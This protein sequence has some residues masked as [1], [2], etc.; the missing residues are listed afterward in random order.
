MRWRGARRAAAVVLGVLAAAGPSAAQAPRPEPIPELVLVPLDLPDPPRGELLIRWPTLVDRRDAM[1]KQVKDHN[2]RCRSV[3]EKSPKAAECVE[4]QKGVRATIAAWAADARRFNADVD[5][6]A[7]QAFAAALQAEAAALA[8]GREAWTV[9]AEA[10]VR[11]AVARTRAWSDDVRTAIAALTIPSPSTRFS[12]LNNLEPGDVL[13]LAP[14]DATGRI[15]VE[16]DRFARTAESFATGDVMQ[17]YATDRREVAHAVTVVKRVAGR[18]LILDHT[19]AGSRMLGERD[20]QRLYGGRSYYVARPRDA[21]DGRTLWSVARDAALQ[22]KSDYGL[23][24][25]KAVC[26]ERAAV[27][28]ARATGRPEPHRLGPVDMTPADFFDREGRG[29]YFVI[30][31]FG[32]DP[33]LA[34]DSDKR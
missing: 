2:D 23:F 9:K 1:R 28:V 34:I 11:D 30:M 18:M 24:G 17:A 27:C 4:A 25:D 10:L 7:E 29:K 22:R 15:I 20:F 6:A 3:P 19:L 14:S 31:P 26:S 5:A 12:T 13:L 8:R 21:V 32:K 16:A 33:T